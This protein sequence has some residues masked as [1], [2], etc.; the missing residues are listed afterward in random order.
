MIFTRVRLP[1][2]VI[3]LLVCFV[4][5]YGLL[6][7]G[8]YSESKSESFSEGLIPVS[9]TAKVAS[10]S[11]VRSQEGVPTG[12]L[13][14]ESTLSFGGQTLSSGGEVLGVWK[15]QHLF[16]GEVYGA[17]GMNRSRGPLSLTDG[18]LLTATRDSTLK[19]R[20]GGEA[21]TMEEFFNVLAFEVKK[22]DLRRGS[23]TNALDLDTYTGK[24]QQPVVLR[25]RQPEVGEKLV[26]I[27]LD[28]T[29]GVYVISVAASVT[30]GDARYNFRVVVK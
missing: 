12:D 26:K 29:P 15:P 28:L 5:V 1:I 21:G 2:V 3:V 25:S 11:G 30:Q 19:F 13:P 17:S 9:P 24:Q 4:G 20:Y 14:P 8:S 10:V 18:N 22:G 6:G 16:A 23:K 27:P 7:T